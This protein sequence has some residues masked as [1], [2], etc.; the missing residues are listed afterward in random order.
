MSIITKGLS[1]LGGIGSRIGRIFEKRVVSGSDL[2]NFYDM[3][4]SNAAGVIVTEDTIKK[5]WIVY[6]CVDYLG[7]MMA[8][9]PFIAYQNLGDGSKTRASEHSVYEM[10]KKAP[11]KFMTPWVLKY[12]IMHHLLITGNFYAE[13]EWSN[14]GFPKNIWPLNPNHTNLVKKDNKL[15]YETVINGQTIELMPYRVIH[16]KN[17]TIDGLNGRSAISS[18]TESY[19]VEIAAKQYGSS[20]FAKGAAPIGV[21]TTPG[22]L[23]DDVQKRVKAQWNDTYGGLSNA[24]RT[25]I[26]EQ[27]LD[28]KSIS[29]SPE[30]AQLI[31]VLRKS[32]AEI[33]AMFGVPLHKVNNMEGSTFSNIESQGIAFITD[34]MRPHAVNIEEELTRKLFISSEADYFIEILLD[35]LARGDLKTRYEAYNTGILAGFL[36]ID[37]V[38]ALENMNPLANGA[39]QVVYRPLNSQAVPLTDEA[40]KTVL[41]Q[42]P[43]VDNN[44]RNNSRVIDEKEERSRANERRELSKTQKETIEDAANKIL[45]R[46]I[47]E[48]KK[49][50]KPEFTRA[51]AK[52]AIKDFYFKIW[53]DIRKIYANPT[54]SYLDS[55]RVVVKSQYGMNDQWNEYEQFVNGYIDSLAS[56]HQQRSQGQLTG[57]VNNAEQEVYLDEVNARFDDWVL[58]RGDKIGREEAVQ[59]LNAGT[60][61]GLILAGFLT[62]VWMADS[63]PCPMCRDLDGQ[64][65]GIGAPFV[66]AGQ[67]VGTEEVNMKVPDT[68]GHGPLHGGCTCTIAPGSF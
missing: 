49:I 12:L 40:A 10:M 50:L 4:A 52:T 66:E 28:F 67:T 21:L 26:L 29:I 20:F 38:R 59:Q 42:P 37:Q 47:R 63:D 54:K 62:F 56:R 32:E 57:I 33:S 55:V 58:K 61:R 6:R 1:V 27:G 44:V 46:E 8:S 15:V 48:L 22:K 25:A 36:I 13:I 24:H 51:Q 17:G 39:G 53:D 65:A 5:L 43:K 34:T 35:A 64:K 11:N 16:I 68:I 18:G 31:Q 9:L 60:K 19:A 45:K 30:D 3:D 14:T 2:S 7:K 23:D 41:V